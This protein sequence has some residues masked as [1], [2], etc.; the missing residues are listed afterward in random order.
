MPI[1]DPVVM[2]LARE[3]LECLEQEMAKVENPPAYV[4]LRSGNVVAHLAST[5]QDECCE[6]LAWVRPAL[7][8]PSSAVFPVQDPAP[9]KGGTRAWAITLEMG[10]VRCAPTPDETRIPTADEWDEVTQAVMDDAAAM[11]RALCCFAE[12]RNGLVLPG[13]WQ[14]LDAQGGCVGGIMPITVRGPA[15]DCSDAGPDSS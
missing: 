5:T 10:A 1:S 3:L 12:T 2:P 4:Q 14:P 7:F 8:A 6:G 11:R 15:C 13:V 9:I